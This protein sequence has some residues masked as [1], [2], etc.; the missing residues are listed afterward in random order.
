M[1]RFG[2]GI[3]LY[4]MDGTATGRWQVTLNNW[5]CSAYKIP[6][7]N[8]KGCDD[9]PELHSPGVYFL[10]GKDDESN[11]RF[12]YVGEGDDA[13]K[14]V[15]QAHNFEKDGSYWTEVVFLLTPYGYLDKAKIKYLENRFHKIAVESKRYLIKNSNTPSQS[16]VQKKTQDELEQFIIN[17][18]LIMAALGHRVFEPQPS[19]EKGEQDVLLYF[20]RNKGKGGQATGKIADDGFWVLKGSFIYPKEAPYLPAGVVNTRKR[21]AA[22]IDNQG[23]LKCDISFGSPS[24]AASFVCGMN[25]NGLLGWKTK[26]GVTLK[27]L[28]ETLPEPTN[29]AKKV[30]KIAPKPE[31]TIVFESIPASTEILHLASKKLVA[32]GYVSDSQFIVLKGSQISNK[33]WKACSNWIKNQRVMLISSGK[34]ANGVFTENVSFASPSTAAAVINGGNSNGQIMWKNAEDTSLKDLNKVSK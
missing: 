7:A 11:R 18:K 9:I 8:L 32:S 22:S 28:N 33:I 24:Y 34:I 19:E 26:D 6:R 20:T 3:D 31:P 25:T 4:L 5:N 15:L 16:P 12:V 10:F 17:A 30:K 23:I 14:R 2:K 29:K 1:A 13:L 27:E 21:Y